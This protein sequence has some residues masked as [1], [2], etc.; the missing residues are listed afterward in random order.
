MG[1]LT[2]GSEEG[3]LE[4]EVQAIIQPPTPFTCW[5]LSPGHPSPD[6]CDQALDL[7][8]SVFLLVQSIKG[9]SAACI[10]ASALRTYKEP[11]APPGGCLRSSH[12]KLAFLK[13]TLGDGTEQSEG[14]SGGRSFRTG[15][16]FR[17]T[18]R[19]FVWPHVWQYHSGDGRDW[20]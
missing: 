3:I 2:L 5:T 4:T 13:G 6:L 16:H 15:T 11:M 17:V 1:L 20:G 8:A 14:H 18:W 10:S 7:L 19:T 9:L 12:V